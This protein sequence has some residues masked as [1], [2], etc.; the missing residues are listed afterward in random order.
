MYLGAVLSGAVLSITSYHLIHW[1][2]KKS[3]LKKWEKR[4]QE[5][6]ARDSENTN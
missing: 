6:A 4:C 1:A 3:A 5:R 2:W